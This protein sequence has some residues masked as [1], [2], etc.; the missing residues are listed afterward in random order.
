MKVTAILPDDLVARIVKLSKGSN[1]TESLLIALRE[2]ASIKEL[3]AIA[4][5]VRKKPLKFRS[6]K[7]IGQLRSTN[8]RIS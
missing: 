6:D 5:Q 4:L 1:T 8:R 2:W 7:A 3:S